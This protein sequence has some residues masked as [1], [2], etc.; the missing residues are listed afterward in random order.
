MSSSI[1]L[2]VAALVGTAACDGSD[3][4]VDSGVLR[5]DA[6]EGC[7]YSESSDATNVTNSVP[8]GFAEVTGRTFAAG[9][10]VTIC[11]AIDV[12][13]FAEPGNPKTLIDSDSFTITVPAESDLRVVLTGN[14][15]AARLT[16]TSP[17]SSSK[18]RP[19][20]RSE[21]ATARGMPRACSLVVTR[22]QARV[23]PRERSSSRSPRTMRRRRR[24]RFRTAS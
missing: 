18:W 11:G 1:A 12:T 6:P 3:A 23:S 10:S 21:P 22:W 5:P 15:L 14:G 2:V 16:R 7:D 20:V 24:R 4:T 17:R 9:S 13:H 19:R 8:S